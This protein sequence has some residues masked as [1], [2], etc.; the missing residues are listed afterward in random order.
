MKSLN[1]I[2]GGR[3]SAYMAL[4][5]PADYNLFACV[6]ID[7]E[8]SK[9]KDVGLARECQN[10]IPNFVASHESDETLRAVLDLEQELGRSIAWVSSEF[11][12]ETFVK[13]RT[14]LPGYRSG[15]ARLFN[16][17]T[18]FC[19][20]QQKIAPIA[21]WVYSNL[22]VDPVMM[23]IGFRWDEPHR[24]EGWN[25]END[26]FRMAVS[27][28]VRGGNWKYQELEWRISHFPLYNDRI[29]KAD[30]DRFWRK[31]GIKFPEISNC[32]FCPF[33]SDIQLQRQALSHPD[34]L[35]WW[36]DLESKSKH[37][38]GK[39]PLKDRLAQPLLDV[40]DMPCQCTA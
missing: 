12:L 24:V 21:H 2:S 13:G 33:H 40:F 18:R 17:Q 26:K 31:K 29:V 35:Q 23:N 32:R 3:T 38:F 14:D 34:N 1:S 8:P 39:R 16:S 27:C 37:T 30:I 9:P 15:K 20:V 28:P 6:L 25:C 4:H 11:P 22:G 7:H 36:L 19:T 10:R 5:Y